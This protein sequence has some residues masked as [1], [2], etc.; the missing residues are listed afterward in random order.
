MRPLRSAG[1]SEE[2]LAKPIRFKVGIVPEC[3]R[4]PD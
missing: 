3:Q 2:H 1:K 4:D